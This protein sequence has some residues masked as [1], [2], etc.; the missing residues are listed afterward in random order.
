MPYALRGMETLI[1]ERN[2]G[3]GDI[4]LPAM[5]GFFWLIFGVSH[6]RLS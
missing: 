5:C 2:V 3:L 6:R 4:D 1:Q